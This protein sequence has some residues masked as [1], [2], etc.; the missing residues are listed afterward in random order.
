MPLCVG[1]T[2]PILMTRIGPARWMT[3][4]PNLRLPNRKGTHLSYAL[5]GGSRCNKAK[6][7]NTI[8][9]RLLYRISWG[10]TMHSETFLLHSSFNT[11][12][13]QEKMSGT[14]FNREYWWWFNA[15]ISGHRSS[16]KEKSSP[17]LPLSLRANSLMCLAYKERPHRLWGSG[18]KLDNLYI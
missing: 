13:F 3:E 15:I 16:V 14:L 8:L 18:D 11:R 17:S 9:A 2:R 6:H 7:I 12:V 5:P 10:N 4:R 1:L